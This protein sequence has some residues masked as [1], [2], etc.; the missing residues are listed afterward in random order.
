MVVGSN[1]VSLWVK[2]E[3]KILALKSWTF[4]STSHGFQ[5]IESE[6][7]G[8][9]GS[10][11]LLEQTFQSKLCALSDPACTLIPPRLFDPEQLE[12]Y[13]QLLL[14]LGPARSYGFEKMEALDCYLVWAAEEGW[15]RLCE[16]YFT[17]ANIR[18]LGVPLLL[19]Y[20][21]LAPLSGYGVFA[22]LSGQ[23]LQTAVFER[24]NLVF[25]NSFDFNKPSDL[26]YFVLL[27]YQQFGLNPLEI[28]LNLS[29]TLLEDSE[30]FRLLQRYIRQ[31]NFLALP[32]EVQLPEQAKLLPAHL[33]YDLSTL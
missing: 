16:H 26:L 24:Q 18:H 11:K 15:M 27:S 25:F 13:F 20:R 17:A 29:G 4:P 12:R 9:F 21:S 2:N 31:L 6:L 19:G 28:P 32:N 33:W 14:P 3:E 22:H 30:I 8:I 23:K 5:G 7:R 10:E 1:G